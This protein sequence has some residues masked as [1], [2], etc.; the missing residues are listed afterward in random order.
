M[1]VLLIGG[2]GLIGYY[3]VPLL[4]QEGN[5]VTV[6]SRGNKPI[7]ERN[8]THITVDRSTA[9]EEQGLL[10]E[11]DVVIDNVAYTP[12][13]CKSLL[14]G[15]RGRIN[16]YIVTSTAFV[17]PQLERS[18]AEPSRPLRESD[19]SFD[20][21]LPERT[22]N[23]AHDRYVYDKQRMERW[24]RQHRE[25]YG[26]K[27]TVIRPLLQMVGPN[28][29]DGRFAWF[30]LR[31]IDGGPIWLPDSARHKAGPCQLSFSGDVAKA[32]IAV[33]QHAT[34]DYAVYNIGQ[35]ELW[36]YE[37]YIDMM[38]TEAGRHTEVHYAPE[39]TLNIRAGGF[40]R[41]SLPYP[42]AFDVSKAEQEL[43]VKPTPMRDWVR[44][45]AAW[46]TNH[47]RDT[48]PSW[49]E[50]RKNELTWSIDVTAKN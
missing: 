5:T 36:T 21:E 13:D 20:D 37:E 39:E 32:I 44:E 6:M 29:E 22:P 49:Y 2:S 11:Y 46:M 27:I 40:Y 41:I 19:A 15:L 3:L 14:D 50:N 35:P 45:T 12:E 9:F 17:Y 18:L 26:I 25:R 43:G 42:V 38:A 47:Y 16:H 33:M 31:V 8:V 23:N 30:W 24:L 28:T 48:S 34:A 1:K 4:V 7:A 10:G